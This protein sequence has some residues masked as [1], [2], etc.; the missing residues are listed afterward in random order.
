MGS[1]EKTYQRNV[2]KSRRTTGLVF[3]AGALVGGAVLCAGPASDA[4][5][6]QPPRILAGASP[7]GPSL[8]KPPEDRRAKKLADLRALEGDVR[9]LVTRQLIEL[10]HNSSRAEGGLFRLELIRALAHHEQELRSSPHQ[11]T[12]VVRT[13]IHLFASEYDPTGTS[14]NPRAGAERHLSRGTAA[15]ALARS[16]HPLALRK[17]VAVA[18]EGGQSDPVGAQLALLALRSIPPTSLQQGAVEPLFSE[19]EIRRL[20]EKA[21]SPTPVRLKEL[22]PQSLVQLLV[23]QEASASKADSR[24]E[25]GEERKSAEYADALALVLHASSLPSSF[26]QVRSWQQALDQQPSATLR[27][28]AFLGPRLPKPAFAFARRASLDRLDSKIESI[29][30]AAAWCLSVLSPGDVN[31]IL[32]RKDS[33]LLLAVLRQ[34]SDGPVSDLVLEALNQR[35]I[36]KDQRETAWRMVLQNPS[37]WPKL[38]TARLRR[39]ESERMPEIHG[40]LASRLRTS[41]HG[42]GP[43]VDAV[44]AWLNNESPEIRAATAHGL[45]RAVTPAARGLLYQAYRT[46]YEPSV[47]RALAAALR[48]TALSQNSDFLELV[49]IDPDVIGR[50]SRHPRDAD[51]FYV[52]WSSRRSVSLRDSEGRFFDIPA[53][54]DGFVGIVRTSF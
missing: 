43:D 53:A 21:A 47:R 17:L 33:A 50:E 6:G 40:P 24:R 30:S 54:P 25:D 45:A 31:A 39:L 13:L 36:P 19:K 27:T 26:Q 51:G 46:E 7:F 2:A 49:S 48:Q 34:A 29:R 22:T 18:L 1:L 35:L 37:I 42:L 4:E 32:E 3:V 20:L 41:A 14:E 9:P 28:L 11:R 10:A 23:G 5:A 44:R 38:S 12:L 52:L 16:K 15:M 8:M